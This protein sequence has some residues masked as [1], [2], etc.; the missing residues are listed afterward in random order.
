MCCSRICRR[1][2]FLGLCL[3]E[4]SNQGAI[5]RAA[6][7]ISLEASPV[8][9]WVIPTDEAQEIARSTYEHLRGALQEEP[10]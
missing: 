3:D 6:K 5:G 4:N 10:K 1:L 7:R 2:E 8:Q 9:V